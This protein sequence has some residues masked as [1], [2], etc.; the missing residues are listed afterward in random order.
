M[1]LHIPPWEKENRLQI[2]FGRGYVSYQ[3]Q[4]AFNNPHLLARSAGNSRFFGMK[5]HHQL[6]CDVCQYRTARRIFQIATYHLMNSW[7]R[8]FVCCRCKEFEGLTGGKKKKRKKDKYMLHSLNLLHSI[9][10]TWTFHHLSLLVD[11]PQSRWRLHTYPAYRAERIIPLRVSAQ[12]GIWVNHFYRIE[13]SSTSNLIKFPP[14]KLKHD[15]LEN[16]PWMSNE[17]V[18]PIEHG[19]YSE[20]DP[21]RMFQVEKWKARSV[22]QQAL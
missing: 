21:E 1:E 16:S 22:G 6:L 7:G 2:S 20:V 14:G 17:D 3:N 15:W 10:F 9:W 12:Q 19:D 13:R 11:Y 5:S 4:L 18:L 8:F